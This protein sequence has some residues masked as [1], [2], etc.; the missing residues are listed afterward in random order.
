MFS[1]TFLMCTGSSHTLLLFL[2]SPFLLSFLVL[3]CLLPCLF[4]LICFRKL[5]KFVIASPSRCTLKLVPLTHSRPDPVNFQYHCEMHS[6]ARL[7]HSLYTLVRWILFGHWCCGYAK[8]CWQQCPPEWSYRGHAS[9]KKEKS[10]SA[11]HSFAVARQERD[12]PLWRHK[13]REDF[14]ADPFTPGLQ[15]VLFEDR[16][17]SGLQWPK[18]TCIKWLEGVCG[19]WW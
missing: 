14:L 2:L 19:V 10:S 16:S 17:P 13:A 15:F 12:S 7:A 4:C 18:D 11:K 8:Q 5:Y 9:G 3:L 1:S 6:D